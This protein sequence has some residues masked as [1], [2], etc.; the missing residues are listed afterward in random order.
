[1]IEPVV[2]GSTLPLEA[3]QAVSDLIAMLGEKYYFQQGETA[4]YWAVILTLQLH[5]AGG[6]E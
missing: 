2:G 6:K 4:A 3:Q 1:M 5:L